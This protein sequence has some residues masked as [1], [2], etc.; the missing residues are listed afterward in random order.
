MVN[1]ILMPMN[2][3]EIEHNAKKL[4]GYCIPGSFFAGEQEE[5]L[6]QWLEETGRRVFDEDLV[7]DYGTDCLRLYLMFEHTPKE[8]DAPFYDSWQEGALEGI[9]K[10]LGRYRRM[11][12]AADEWNKRDRKSVA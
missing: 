5:K 12:L 6:L 11:I 8:N 10:F 7:M 4:S 9:Y 2:H 1:E 3:R